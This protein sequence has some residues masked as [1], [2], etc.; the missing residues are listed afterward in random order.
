MKKILV[1][2]INFFAFSLIANAQIPGADIK[3]Q[4]ASGK[5]FSINDLK[6]DNG[7]LVIFINNSCDVVIK[8]QQRQIAVSDLA[9]RN[10]IG[11]V[12]INSSKNRSSSESISAMKDYANTQNFNWEY[13][14]DDGGKI[15]SAFGASKVPVV[16]L[17]NKAGKL[18]Y[19]GAIDDNPADELGVTQ[20]YL[21]QAI[22]NL[23]AGKDVL[24]KKSKVIGC[25]IKN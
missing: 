21:R 11:V 4:S 15:A 9:R 25:S 7:L 2:F 23:V 8:G 22:D 13:L 14:A 19:Q 5:Q 10:N 16:Y 3:M 12:Y 1:L 24:I 17:Y 18:V 6:K 20:Q